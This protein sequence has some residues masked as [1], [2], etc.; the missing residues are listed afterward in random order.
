M[1]PSVA[2]WFFIII[3]IIAIIAMGV[4][5]VGFIVNNLLII[6][7]AIFLVIGIGTFYFSLD[8]K[9]TFP[10]S[11]TNLVIS[12]LPCIILIYFEFTFISKFPQ[13]ISIAVIIAGFIFMIIV[14]LFKNII[15]YNGGIRTVFWLMLI[16]LCLSEKVGYNGYP[17]SE[18]IIAKQCIAYV[19]TYIVK[20]KSC[21]VYD[22][23]DNIDKAGYQIAEVKSGDVL[24]SQKMVTNDDWASVTVGNQT[25]YMLKDDLKVDK[26]Y[27][28]YELYYPN[29]NFEY[30]ADDLI[31]A[32]D[33]IEW[34]IGS[35]WY[36]KDNI[37]AS[38]KIKNSTNYDI[39][40]ISS[41]KI[42][43]YNAFDNQI[44]TF[45]GSILEKIKSGEELEIEFRDKV[46]HK[47]T[48][49]LGLNM[50]VNYDLDVP[51]FYQKYE[52][53]FKDS[54]N[55]VIYSVKEA[56]WN[57]FGQLCVTFFVTNNTESSLTRIEEMSIDV[58]DDNK[59]VASYAT[60]MPYIC[61]IKPGQYDE[62]MVTIG[63]YPSR[64]M[65]DGT[66]YYTKETLYEYDG[67][68]NNLSI[69]GTGNYFYMRN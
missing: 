14:Y 68:L 54:D 61:D 36:D 60:E 58:M 13:S 53:A 20:N 26:A 23:V 67:K 43:L 55:E 45:T 62:C 42:K 17:I 65:K 7:I 18:I 31:Y 9:R 11:V 4:Q 38:V 22:S 41:I 29:R 1:D 28:Y 47:D 21:F 44:A 27:T 64:I 40:N 50:D 25:G 52:E 34:S 49:V 2:I 3:V 16:V 63:N 39:A 46:Y 8:Q 10:E 19:D 33:G 37:I 59:M 51:Y 56:Y 24:I 15:V 30:S 12:F 35:I 32:A 5:F 69:S 6:A 48:F 66:N 57:S